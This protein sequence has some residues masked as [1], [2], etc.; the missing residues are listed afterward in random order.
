ME[1]LGDEVKNRIQGYFKE[2]GISIESNENMSDIIKNILIKINNKS[3]IITD[4][5]LN[6]IIGDEFYIRMLKS[7]GK[8]HLMPLR[9][10]VWRK[11]F[12]REIGELAGN[13]YFLNYLLKRAKEMKRRNKEKEILKMVDIE[14]KFWYEHLI[15]DQEKIDGFEFED[16]YDLYR[17]IDS[18]SKRFDDAVSEKNIGEFKNYLKIKQPKRGYV[19]NFKRFFSRGKKGTNTSG[20]VFWVLT[21]TIWIIFNTFLWVGLFPLFRDVIAVKNYIFLFALIPAIIFT[22]VSFYS[23]TYINYLFVASKLYNWAS[24]LGEEVIHAEENWFDLPSLTILIPIYKEKF[25]YNWDDL[26]R[27]SN[28]GKTI[29]EQLKSKKCYGSEYKEFILNQIEENLILNEGDIQLYHNPAV[30]KR[31][32]EWANDRLQTVWKTLNDSLRIGDA[33]REKA[34]KYFGDLSKEDIEE[35]VNEKIQILVSHD[36]YAKYE[37]LLKK[38]KECTN[39]TEDEMEVI[40][41]VEKVKRYCE[42]NG[43]EL[44]YRS[45]DKIYTN[46]AGNLSFAFCY[47]RGD[48]TLLIDADTE[49]RREAAEKMPNILLEFTKDPK[50]ALVQL[51]QYVF[52]E[53]YNIIT[54][55][56]SIPTNT[57]WTMTLRAKNRIGLVL[58]YGHAILLRT[59]FMKEQEGIQPD[60]GSAEDIMEGLKFRTRGLNT[61]YIDYLELGEGAETSLDAVMA[62]IERWATSVARL[63]R[64]KGF[65]DFLFETKIPLNEKIDTLFGLGFFFEKPLILTLLFSCIIINIILK[66]NPSLS[67]SPWLLFTGWIFVTSLAVNGTMFLYLIEK[68]GVVKGILKAVV[69][70]L[71]VFPI[72]ISLI[73]IHSQG[74]IKG[75]FGKGRIEFIPSDKSPIS[76]SISLSKVYQRAYLSVKTMIIGIGSLLVALYYPLNI[77][78]IL[79][80]SIFII[81]GST[82]FLFNFVPRMRITAKKVDKRKKHS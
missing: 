34:E 62:Q 49:I 40:M 77:G 9:D 58:G 61:K 46:K 82:P 44:I 55:I 54:K 73:P 35:V 42:E 29:F 7:D 4:P 24:P 64:K 31:I 14:R 79:F 41:N 57:W 74:V 65:K 10:Y 52:N 80:I 37:E 6:V 30:I 56:Q 8:W 71:V 33:Y 50:L 47:V 12:E 63:V 45:A 21:L 5:L 72:Y 1:A 17:D 18:F 60:Y 43:I 39:L 76:N 28:T 32:E 22:V 68:R 23:I 48:I 69:T 78:D 67:L 66:I 11:I 70:S 27:P 25:Y 51:K 3:S 2:L 19:T 13:I 16:F 38:R 15:R 26:N 59:E 36:G 75:Y 53:K 20:K 81:I